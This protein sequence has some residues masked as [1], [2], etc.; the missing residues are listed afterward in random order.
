MKVP[1]EALAPWPPTVMAKAVQPSWLKEQEV[2]VQDLMAVM[3]LM[4]GPFRIHQSLSD[5]PKNRN[6]NSH[7]QASQGSPSMR[8]RVLIPAVHHRV[9]ATTSLVKGHSWNM[10]K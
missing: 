4:I 5:I 7:R 8:R 3:V 2:V 1:Q 9:G 6:R 10:R